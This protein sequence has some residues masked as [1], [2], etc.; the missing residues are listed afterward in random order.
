MYDIFIRKKSERLIFPCFRFDKRSSSK[1]NK[2]CEG[3]PLLWRRKYSIM[4][5]KTIFEEE[6]AR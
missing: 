2:L 5:L 4:P 1:F 6:T 3:I